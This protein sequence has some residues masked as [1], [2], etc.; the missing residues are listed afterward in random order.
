MALFWLSDEAWMAIEPHL[1]RTSLARD[2]WTTRRVI[3]GI[4]MC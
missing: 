2:G 4:C 1:P 3:S